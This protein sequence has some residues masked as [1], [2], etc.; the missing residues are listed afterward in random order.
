[1]TNS[2]I[3]VVVVAAFY[4]IFIQSN[5]SPF[6]RKMLSANWPFRGRAYYIREDDYNGLIDILNY[7]DC[8]QWLKSI[9]TKCN[10]NIDITI[11]CV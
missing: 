7:T 9:R 11:I 1:M 2:T 10:S 6:R 3:R 5:D 4:D 8:L